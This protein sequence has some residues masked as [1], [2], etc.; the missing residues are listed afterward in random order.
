MKQNKEEYATETVC[1]PQSFKIFTNCSFIE[2]VHPPQ[3][4]IK[5]NCF[6]LVTI[7]SFYQDLLTAKQTLSYLHFYPR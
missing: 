1:V 7:Q 3:L 2:R 4:K 6:W 5:K